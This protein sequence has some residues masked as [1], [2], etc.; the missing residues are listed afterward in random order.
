[1]PLSPGHFNKVRAE[2]LDKKRITQKCSNESVE[3]KRLRLKSKEE[4]NISETTDEVSRLSFS[5]IM[6]I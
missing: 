2:C 3:K 4:R 6:I 5:P 1:M